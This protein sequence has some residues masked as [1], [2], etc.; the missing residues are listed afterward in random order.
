MNLKIFIPTY[1]RVDRQV[2]WDR[3]PPSIRKHTQLVVSH[4]EAPVHHGA[5]RNYVVSP[6]QGLGMAAIRGWIM[7]HA[8]V[9]KYKKIVILDDDLILQR[10]RPDG[11][12]TDLLAGEY[13]QAFGWMERT[14]DKV[15]HCAMGMRFLAWNSKEEYF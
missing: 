2:T 12:I 7:R 1:K 14:L 9:N 11:R 5:N 10:R 3:F 8:V 15:A 6:R 13:E 4:E